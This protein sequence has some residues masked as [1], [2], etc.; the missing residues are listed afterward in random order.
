M[1]GE[2]RV[3]EQ[4]QLLNDFILDTLSVVLPFVCLQKHFETSL[5]LHK[6]ARIY[7]THYAITL[8]TRYKVLD[9]FQPPNTIFD[10]LISSPL[11]DMFIV[12]MDHVMCESIPAA[13]IPLWANPRTYPGHLKKNSNAR[14]CGQFLLANALPPSP[15]DQ[16]TKLLVAIFQ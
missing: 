10:V 15:S 13:S 6:R 14:P 1:F 11:H 4:D 12:Q 3:K 7:S 16:Y 2:E 9:L 5:F 8:F